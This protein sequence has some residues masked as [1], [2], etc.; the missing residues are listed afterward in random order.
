MET[1]DLLRVPAAKKTDL[2]IVFVE[3]ENG[4]SDYKELQYFRDNNCIPYIFFSGFDF[5][6]NCKCLGDSLAA[7]Y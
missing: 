3:R 6:M 5:F 1:Y 7:E 2:F 4:F